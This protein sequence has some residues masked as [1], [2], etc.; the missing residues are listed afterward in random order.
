VFATV[1]CIVDLR[2]SCSELDEIPMKLGS[3]DQ[4]GG[5]LPPPMSEKF[6]SK[7]LFSNGKVQST[8][9]QEHGHTSRSEISLSYC[10]WFSRTEC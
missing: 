3:N 9:N 5:S 7:S 2:G 10:F 8:S 1:S 4:A 6:P